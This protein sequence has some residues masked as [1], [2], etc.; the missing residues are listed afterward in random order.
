MKTRYLCFLLI[1]L[2][3]ASRL[4]ASDAVPVPRPE[5]PRPQFVR[6]EWVNLNGTWSFEFD[7]SR[8]GMDRKLYESKGFDNEIL[9][10]FAPQSG[11]SG[12]G[13]KDFIPEM[14]YHRVISIP[15][16]WKDRNVI[17][18]F[19]AV[20]YIA[21]VYIDGRIAGRHWGGSSSFDIDITDMV[22]P[23]QE[24][25]LVVRVEDD[26]RSGQYA[27]GKQ[28]GRFD[29]FG[30]EYTRT[31]G[32]W[33][34]VWMEPVSGTGLKDI[35]VIPDLDQSRF[36]IEPSYY[37][38]S[39]GQ[40]LRVRV[41]DG[42]RVVSSAVVPSSAQSYAE[43]P[44]RKA[45]TWSP[46]SPFLYGIELEVISADGSV[47][48]RVR[49]YAGMRKIHIEGN[50]IYLNN[51]PVYLRFVLDQGFYP[52]GIWTA[53]DD[54]A[55]KRDIELS[56]AAGFNGARLHQKVFEPR[57]HYWADKLGYLTWGESASWGANVN[58]PLSARHFLT[59]WEETVVRDRNHPSIIVWTPFNETWEHPEDREAA[60]EA[61]RMVSDVYKLTK[62]LDY[63]PCHDVS[64]NYHVMTD[65][66]SV[67]QY[68]QDPEELRGWLAPENGLVRQADLE[69][70]ETEYGGQPYLVDEYGGIKWVAGREYSEISWGYGDA[71]KT[72][73][74]FYRRL[75]GL[76]DVIL[77]YGH[78]CGYC[79][80]QLTDVEQE[81]NG[82]YSYDRTPKFDMDRIRAIFTKV[83]D[84]FC[85]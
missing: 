69:H 68:M 50:R 17:L 20:D 53:P 28:C 75:E 6:D 82:I 4:A 52:D 56:M 18:H 30:C 71:P 39:S 76:T 65:I 34:T 83:P 31:T 16:N 70:R 46:E 55:L 23:G 62:N 36:I 72:L 8:S 48:D 38:L 45:R 43:L 33:Q 14:W 44:V 79:Y 80:T 9:V 2:G 84:G 51:E 22:M 77:G 49:S 63:R 10:P 85:K 5:Y 15:E 3:T 41:L 37:G 12:V 54:Q 40:K 25:D 64:G 66:F 61:C 57:F 26:E 29:S 24:H 19:G 32:I 13:F 59:E 47:T 60:R 58:N 42:D 21:S 67:H 35:Y 27:K 81:Q 73:E 1:L 11:L 7:F 78:I 74:E